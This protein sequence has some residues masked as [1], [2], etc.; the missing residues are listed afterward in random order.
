VWFV[1]RIRMI[2][3]GKGWIEES[4]SSPAKVQNKR[5]RPKAK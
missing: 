2:R 4:Q 3:K 5:Q 1:R